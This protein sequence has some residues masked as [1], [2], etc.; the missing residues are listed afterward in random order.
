MGGA[1]AATPVHGGDIPGHQFFQDFCG[2]P[3]RLLAVSLRLSPSSTEKR[4]PARY[5]LLVTIPCALRFA[6]QRLAHPGLVQESPASPS[7]GFPARH[8]AVDNCAS[9]TER[10]VLIEQPNNSID[11]L[12]V[13]RLGCATW[14]ADVSLRE[15]REIAGKRS[16]RSPGRH[17]P[18]LRLWSAYET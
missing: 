3:A 7:T 6:R 16:W 13:K 4:F 1:S 11:N 5:Q 12:L 9:V 10:R 18:C 15:A 14:R 2:I 17:W 8:S